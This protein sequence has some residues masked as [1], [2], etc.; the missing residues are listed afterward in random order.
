MQMLVFSIM[1]GLVAPLAFGSAANLAAVVLGC[2]GLVRLPFKAPSPGARRVHLPPRATGLSAALRHHPLTARN[3]PFPTGTRLVVKP[4]SARTAAVKP[5]MSSG[6]EQALS[7]TS[8]PPG[9]S[10]RFRSGHHPR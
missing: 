10:T 1:S 2:S 6:C 8:K 7:T 9:R 5:A 3:S 4:P